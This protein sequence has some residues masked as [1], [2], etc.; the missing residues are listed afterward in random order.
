[1][2]KLIWMRRWPLLLLAGLLVTGCGMKFVYNK[3]DWLIPLW[4]S[5]YVTLDDAQKTQLDQR[6]ARV[7]EWHRHQQ[8]AQYVA[9]IRRI[10]QA[11]GDGLDEAAIEALFAAGEAYW[12]ALQEKVT[13][14]VADILRTTSASQRQEIYDKFSDSNAEFRA[15]YFGLTEEKR[16]ARSMDDMTDH[17]EPWL[18]D[19][20]EPQRQAVAEFVRSYYPIHELRYKLRQNV[21]LELR[22]ILEAEL[23]P[24][25]FQQRIA[26]LLLHQENF[27]PLG[28]D[29]KLAA[30]RRL[31]VA[32]IARVMR[33]RDAEQTAHLMHELDSY[34]ASFQE[35]SLLARVG[36]VPAP[37]RQVAG[38]GT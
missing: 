12:R 36:T 18:G 26:T 29:D 11:V 14:D 15:K 2:A 9:L 10:Q 25:Q 5:T 16:I 7:L 30:N 37:G 31:L 1:M 24:V 28:Y 4:I 22:S 33:Q 35:L 3:L 6:L 38:A 20:N 21:Q 17:F 13:P 19:L 32:L 23:S 8:L 34:A 27:Y